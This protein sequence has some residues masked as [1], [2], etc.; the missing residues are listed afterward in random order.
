[1]KFKEHKQFGFC[2]IQKE[3][4]LSLISTVGILLPYQSICLSLIH[5]I[6]NIFVKFRRT[7]SNSQAPLLFSKNICVSANFPIFISVI[8]T[9]LCTKERLLLDLNLVSSIMIL[10]VYKPIIFHFLPRIHKTFCCQ[11]LLENREGFYISC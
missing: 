3:S 9:L 6:A 1:M 5:S 2:I 11:H 7:H 8:F 10:N 4:Y